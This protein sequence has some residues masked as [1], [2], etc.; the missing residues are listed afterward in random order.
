MDQSTTTAANSGLPPQAEI[1]ARTLQAYKTA[2][3]PLPTETLKTRPWFQSN[4]VQGA[5]LGRAVSALVRNGELRKAGAQGI[6][7]LGDGTPQRSNQASTSAQTRKPARP[8]RSNG[9]NQPMQITGANLP[10]SATGTRSQSRSP[11]KRMT[12]QA[13]QRANQRQASGQQQYAQRANQL[14]QTA[15]QAR[16]MSQGQGNNQQLVQRI[17]R[18]EKQLTAIG[19]AFRSW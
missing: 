1:M 15:A 5:A 16:T 10:K 17:T 12:A 8:A 9:T 4:G 3:G 19:N 18:L 6:Y 13:G 2:R 7:E 11:A 14:K